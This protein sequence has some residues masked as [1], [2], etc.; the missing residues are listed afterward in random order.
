MYLLENPWKIRTQGTE[1][2][3]RGGYQEIARAQQRQP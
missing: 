3:Y 2:D 1:T